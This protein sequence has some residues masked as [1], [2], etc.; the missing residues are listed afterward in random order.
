MIES[1]DI[2]MEG[3]RGQV[4]EFFSAL[5]LNQPEAQMLAR[6]FGEEAVNAW[7]AMFPKHPACVRLKE[8]SR[9]WERG[10]W[11]EEDFLLD[12]EALFRV[13]GDGY[14]HPFESVYCQEGFAAGKVKTCS[15]LAKQA[16]EVASVYR[17]Q[18]LT[19]R[20]GF[21]EFPDH[22]GVELELMAVLCRKTAEALYE[23]N[24][25]DAVRLASQQRS[26]LLRHLYE[27]AP[28]C[29]DKVRKNGSTPLYV[30]MADLM[31]AFLAKE[32]ELSCW[33]SKIAVS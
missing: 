16:R 9:A 3:A 2:H 14:V 21:T 6:L 23:G 18:G 24:R 5:F 11:Q 19:P 17:E 13:P 8:L 10:E 31:K 4:Y 15:V 25:D 32:D 29:M 22:L 7:E 28:R 27:W 33:L 12:Y 1:Q 30:C 26:F 20:E